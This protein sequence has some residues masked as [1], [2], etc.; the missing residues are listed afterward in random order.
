VVN[1]VLQQKYIQFVVP[2]YINEDEDEVV[3]PVRQD[4]EA[5][6]FLQYFVENY[7]EKQNKMKIFC[8]RLFHYL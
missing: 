1:N 8:K 4:E 3:I 6:K 7:M 5:R 2:E